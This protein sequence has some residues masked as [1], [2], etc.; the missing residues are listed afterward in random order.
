MAGE[1][2]AP[3][4]RAVKVVVWYAGSMTSRATA[5]LVSTNRSPPPVL[6]LSAS[7]SDRTSSSLILW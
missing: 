7:R 3:V 5:T 6:P 1:P 2:E 4:A